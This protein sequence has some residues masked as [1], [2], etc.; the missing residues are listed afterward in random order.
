MISLASIKANIWALFALTL[1]LAIMINH[2]G[3]SLKSTFK[4]MR[5]IFILLLFVFIARALFSPGTPIFEFVGISVTKEGISDG[6]VVCWRLFDV[7]V[8]GVLLVST[9]RSSEVKAAVEWF[10]APIPLVPAKRVSTMM[11]LLLRFLPVILDQARETADAQR[12]RGIENRKNPVYRMRKWGVPLMRRTFERADKLALAM[13]AR[14]YS[15]ERTDQALASNK[16][17]WLVLAAVIGM[18]AVMLIS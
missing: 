16:N 3:L 2:V 1:A 6:I 15:E 11:G 12:A 18:C 14:C 7:I 4:S 13:E 9:T 8:L 5:H 10:F 17:D